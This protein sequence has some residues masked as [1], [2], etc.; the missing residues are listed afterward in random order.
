M[1]MNM[2][3]VQVRGHKDLKTVAPQG[4][5]QLHT[6]AVRL[7]WRDL[8]SGKGLVA[9]IGDDPA[10]LVPALFGLLHLVAG[11]FRVAVDAGHK[12]LALGFEIVG[13]VIHHVPQCL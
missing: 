13:G 12:Q 7:L 8:A 10:F 6:D 11:K 5:R 3:C 9:V 1:V 2:A 4:L